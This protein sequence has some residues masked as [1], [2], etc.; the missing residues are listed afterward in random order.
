MWSLSVGVAPA[1]EFGVEVDK[2]KADG[3]VTT[4]IAGL[5][6]TQAKA[7]LTA[8][9]ASGALGA[10]KVGAKAEGHGETP[11]S[12]T[13][14]VNEFEDVP[15]PVIA[16]DEVTEE[17]AE[18]ADIVVDTPPAEP[19]GQPTTTATPSPGL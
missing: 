18:P 13:I 12:F 9:A 11:A 2:T 7:M 16:D 15:A 5:Q 8:L 4:G 10:G 6:I 3:D 14:T 1:A 19:P 17:A